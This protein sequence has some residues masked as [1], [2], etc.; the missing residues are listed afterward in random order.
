MVPDMTRIRFSFFAL[1]LCIAY[2][3]DVVAVVA[4]EVLLAFALLC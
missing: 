4:L 2:V 1:E 3:G